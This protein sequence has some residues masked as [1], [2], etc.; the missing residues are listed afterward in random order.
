[1]L[2]RWVAG[3]GASKVRVR[4]QVAGS[5]QI[6]RLVGVKQGQEQE[7]GIKRE[8]INTKQITQSAVSLRKLPMMA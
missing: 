4:Y 6:N 1:M 7:A 2:R 5:R 8:L 3:S